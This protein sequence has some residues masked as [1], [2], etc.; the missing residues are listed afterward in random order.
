MHVGLPPMKSTLALLSF[1][2]YL[3]LRSGHIS[4]TVLRGEIK[5]ASYFNLLWDQSVEAHP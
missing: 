4:V 2:L 5:D 3:E 1:Q